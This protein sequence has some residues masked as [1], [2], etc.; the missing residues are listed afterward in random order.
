M[1]LSSG[2]FFAFNSQ[3]QKNSINFSSKSYCLPDKIEH[4]FFFKKNMKTWILVSF[5][6]P[7]I[8]KPLYFMSMIF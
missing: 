6:L 8:I 7:I 1:L 3:Q 2:R 4:C 5:N